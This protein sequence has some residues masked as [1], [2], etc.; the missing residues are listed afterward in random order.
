MPSYIVHTSA[1]CFQPDVGTR[2]FLRSL[3]LCPAALANLHYP[4]VPNDA[5]LNAVSSAFPT[6]SQLHCQIQFDPHGLRDVLNTALSP[7]VSPSA[8]P[9]R[10]VPPQTAS[11]P[12]PPQLAVTFLV[13]Q[14]LAQCTAKVH[15]FGGAC[16]LEQ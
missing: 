13:G 5:C 6:L 10:L 16:L 1:S 11:H 14:S 12:G 2:R 15:G 9:S 7:K 3:S 8:S 4:P